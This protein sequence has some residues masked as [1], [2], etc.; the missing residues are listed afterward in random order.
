MKYLIVVI[1]AL[2]ALPLV[3][4]QPVAPNLNVVL[5]NQTPFPAEPGD[6]V[7][8]EIELQNN[9]FG[10]ASQVTMEFTENDPFSL[11]I[12]E[13]KVRTF[14]LIPAQESVKTSFKILIDPDAIS[15]AYQLAFLINSLGGSALT[16]EVT[17]DVQGEARIIID[18]VLVEPKQVEAGGQ[19]IVDIH[20][21]NV[22]SGT[23]RHMLL[24]LNATD[25]IIPTLS[26]GSIYLDDLDP[27]ETSV[28]QMEL[29]VDDGAEEKTYVMKLTVTYDD[30]ANIEITETF[31]LGIP[32]SGTVRLDVIKVEANYER[33]LVEIEV[34]NKGST[35]AKSVEASLFYDGEFV[36]IDY[37]S[38][39]KA[40]KITTFT[41]PLILEGQGTLQ[42][43]Y[44]GPGLQENQVEKTV[45]FNF[46]QQSSGGNP[47]PV[48]AVIIIV[49]LVLFWWLRR[50]RKKK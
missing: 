21:R 1:L 8:I 19:A 38:T 37:I 43:D 41:F 42:I 27:G 25:D 31:D 44:I 14:Q 6:V 29:S 24:T 3:A 33:Q 30:E 39:I 32:V 23:A 45:S 15:D 13:E 4:A 12:G 16:E 35:E 20:V 49:G 50:K 36:D 10:S 17:L 48:L 28:A 9:G 22:G 26:K 34:A 47:L 2:A 5:V 46:V 11:V 40:N 7:E 18:Q